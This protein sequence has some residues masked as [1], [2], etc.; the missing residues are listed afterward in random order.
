MNQAWSGLLVG[1]LALAGVAVTATVSYRVAK[2]KVRQ[3]L[4]I[5]YDK[6]LRARR[7]THYLE[8]WKLLAPLARYPE[9]NRLA[10]QD[11]ERLSNEL[12]TWYFDRGGLFLSGPTRD[13]YFALQDACRVVK[14]KDAGTWPAAQEVKPDALWTALGWTPAWAPS[15][16]TLLALAAAAVK[17]GDD[18]LPDD[19]NATLRNLG[20]ALRTSIAC[21]VLTRRE[22]ALLQDRALEV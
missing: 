17:P 18:F 8:L 19:V 13:H 7:I 6:D 10:A 5:E 15:R 3:E 12:K 4:E 14:L 11:V 22:T 9:P 2:A 20:H 21:D 16:P 1:V